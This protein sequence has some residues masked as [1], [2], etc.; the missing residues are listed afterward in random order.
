MTSVIQG[1]VSGLIWSAILGTCMIVLAT[2]LTATVPVKAMMRSKA[3]E[4]TRALDV[5]PNSETTRLGRSSI[6]HGCGSRLEGA[7]AGGQQA[8]RDQDRQLIRRAS[9]PRPAVVSA[10]R[11]ASS[12]QS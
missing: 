12:V 9:G 10:N 5:S 8:V 6:L 2:V 7:I 1:L 4:V 11:Q 3:A